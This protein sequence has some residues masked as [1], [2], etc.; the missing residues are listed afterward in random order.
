MMSDAL[1]GI[2]EIMRHG[3]GLARLAIFNSLQALNL[4]MM[5]ARTG[6]HR[7]R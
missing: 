3:K 2:N 6:N 7:H 1:N 4:T 5:I